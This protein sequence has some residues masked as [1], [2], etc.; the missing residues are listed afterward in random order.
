[1]AAVTLWGCFSAL[2]RERKKETDMSFFT[3][4]RHLVN[5]SEDIH[6]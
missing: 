4:H 3:Y 6:I 2:R 5:G 1:M